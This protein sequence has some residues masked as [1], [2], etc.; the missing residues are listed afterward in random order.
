MTDANDVVATDVVSSQKGSKWQDPGG[1]DCRY[2]GKCAT[3]GDLSPLSKLPSHEFQL[4]AHQNVQTSVP[5]LKSNKEMLHTLPEMHLPV[6][7]S[8]AEPG[9]VKHTHQGSSAPDYVKAIGKNVWISNP[10]FK[11]KPDTTNTWMSYPMI[12]LTDKRLEINITPDLQ[13]NNVA[14]LFPQKQIKG[15][16]VHLPK[17]PAMPTVPNLQKSVYPIPSQAQASMIMQDV[18]PSFISS[19]IQPKPFITSKSHV[20]N[21]QS[22]AIHPP[23]L[24]YNPN[25]LGITN[26]HSVPM[27]V[28]SVPAINPLPPRPLPKQPVHHPHKVIPVIVPFNQHAS[29]SKS[30][31]SSGN[32]RIPGVSDTT[33]HGQIF[34][35]DL[36]QNVQVLSQPRPQTGI[37][38]LKFPL[39][40]TD[41]RLQRKANFGHVHQAGSP[42]K[43]MIIAGSNT[44]SQN[45][46]AKAGRHIASGAHA[47]A[48]SVSSNHQTRIKSMGDFLRMA[49]MKLSSQ[50]I[51]QL[52]RISRNHQ[53]TLDTILKGYIN[54]QNNAKIT[55]LFNAIYKVKLLQLIQFYQ[56]L[57]P[58]SDHQKRVEEIFIKSIDRLRNM[59]EHETVLTRTVTQQGTSVGGT[60][61]GG[62]ASG[63]NGIV[64]G[65]GGAGGGA[66]VGAAGAGGGAYV[67]AAGA[68]GGPYVGTAGAGG[69]GSASE[70]AEG[71]EI[72]TELESD[73]DSDSDED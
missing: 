59:A 14:K 16:P 29:L 18:K 37:Q 45:S 70:N 48:T 6:L 47:G 13:V 22:Q 32:P 64:S 56:Y 10:H 17:E 66:Y 65:G 51:S 39:H 41:N 20:S 33:L 12:P 54:L 40:A 61:T 9:Q 27:A 44:L 8:P 63:N 4:L 35:K 71:V 34:A 57:Q 2:T 53:H 36:L 3:A 5:Q 58:G 67:G 55:K 15:I 46:I 50:D 68:G 24:Q 43:K 49:Q 7:H 69:G 73:D 11:R 62:G 30:S 19:N 42:M 1:W 23:P 60:G 31:S 21:F 38:I 26:F 28:M 72:D 52:L 25:V